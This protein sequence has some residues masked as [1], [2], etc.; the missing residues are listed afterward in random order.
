VGA[1]LDKA[2]HNH[3]FEDVRVRYA[4]SEEVL[5]KELLRAL[6][7]AG[8]GG[9]LVTENIDLE[10]RVIR[11]GAGTLRVSTFRKLLDDGNEPGENN[12]SNA[13]N[14]GGNN[15]NNRPPRSN[16]NNRR[17][18]N[19]DRGPRPGNRNENQPSKPQPKPQSASGDT[20]VAEERVDRNKD[21]IS[22]M[23]DLVDWYRSH[24]KHRNGFFPG[25]GRKPFFFSHYSDHNYSDK[26]LCFNCFGF[27]FAAPGQ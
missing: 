27:G 17:E 4:K 1:P 6:K 24:Y 18:R 15:A 5:E 2:P 9:V 12:N 26:T 10:N 14:G 11:G 21:V 20:D 8:S 22:Q 23:I 3:V 25:F 7:Q 13:N 16:N 19:R